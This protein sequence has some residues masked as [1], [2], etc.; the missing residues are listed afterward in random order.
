MAL[1]LC[2]LKLPIRKVV[3]WT[4]LIFEYVEYGYI[5]LKG[6]PVRVVA[7]KNALIF[8]ILPV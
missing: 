1:I 6:L 3:S 5:V 4:A 2:V 7:S 8:R